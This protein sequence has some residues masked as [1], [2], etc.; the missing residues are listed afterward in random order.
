[1]GK[2]ER[3]EDLE[4]WKLARVLVNQVYESSRKSHFAK[5]YGLKNQVRRS[6]VSV[7]NNISEGFES[8]TNKLFINYLGQAKAS[9][10]E[11]RSMLFVSLDSNYISD[12]VF[13]ELYD[14]C[15]KISRKI[16]K[17]ISYL[18]DY[19][20]NS[21]VKEVMIEYRGGQ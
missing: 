3:F 10:G 7:M 4:I 2:I 15:V 1:M 14:L 12:I 18:E 17:L 21:R 16:Q 9:C 11:T 5:D 19:N 20:S 8:R 6:S 13:Q